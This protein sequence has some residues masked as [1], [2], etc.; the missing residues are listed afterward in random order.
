V[1]I[2]FT[3]LE[4]EKKL[5]IEAQLQLLQVQGQIVGAE[6]ETLLRGILVKAAVPESM[7]PTVRVLDDCIEVPEAPK[8]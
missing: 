5:R 3:E 6:R 2:E 8:E 1:R 7:W 4:R